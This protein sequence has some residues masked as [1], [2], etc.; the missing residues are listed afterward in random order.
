MFSTKNR[1]ICFEYYF[2]SILHIK[3]EK[4][5]ID[6]LKKK[7]FVLTNIRINKIKFKKKTINI[8]IFIFAIKISKYENTLLFI[9]Q[10]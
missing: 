8:L 9:S 2:S 1:K 10:I 7:H 3:S 6:K 4:I 5:F